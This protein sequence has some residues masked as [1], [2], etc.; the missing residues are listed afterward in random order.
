MIAAR[1]ARIFTDLRGLRNVAQPDLPVAGSIIMAAR[2]N[3]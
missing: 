1:R 3:E 2:T